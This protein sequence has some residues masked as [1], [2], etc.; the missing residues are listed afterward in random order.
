MQW[1][2]WKGRKEEKDA[3]QIA[4]LLRYT[5]F[6]LDHIT[7]SHFVT[8]VNFSREIREDSY[9]LRMQLIFYYST[10]WDYSYKLK[11]TNLRLQNFNKWWTRKVDRDGKLKLNEILVNKDATRKLMANKSPSESLPE[12]TKGLLVHGQVYLTLVHMLKSLRSHCQQRSRG[13]NW[14]N[15]G[16]T[17]RM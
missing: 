15:L 10:T 14:K 3:Y 12:C 2:L 7:W 11:W 17:R 6:I 5:S 8:L 4:L 16:I 9:R 1:L 13:Q